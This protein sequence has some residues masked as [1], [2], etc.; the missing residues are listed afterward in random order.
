MTAHG[1]RSCVSCHFTVGTL[2]IRGANR[3]AQDSRPSSCAHNHSAARPLCHADKLPIGSVP[4]AWNTL[5]SPT[6]PDNYIL[7]C[8]I[9]L[10]CHCLHGLSWKVRG[11]SCVSCHSPHHTVLSLP[12]CLAFRRTVKKLQAS[13]GFNSAAFLQCL[14]HCLEPEDA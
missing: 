4:S 14:A 10:R 6:S 13:A 9:Q 5:L 12:A 1:G 2:S 11:H 3:L 8:G 7:P